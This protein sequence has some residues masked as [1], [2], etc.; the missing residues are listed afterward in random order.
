[1]SF[2]KLAE[3]FAKTLECKGYKW[4]AAA[5]KRLRTFGTLFVL[6]AEGLPFRRRRAFQNYCRKRLFLNIKLKFKCDKVILFRGRLLSWRKAGEIKQIWLERCQRF[7]Q[8]GNRSGIFADNGAVGDGERSWTYFRR[9]TYTSSAW[10][11]LQNV[12]KHVMPSHSHHYCARP[13]EHV[14]LQVLWNPG[15]FGFFMPC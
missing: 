11:W 7:Q 5:P 10:K 14:P 1:M 2:T 12:S 13:H 8:I 6:E 15:L 3:L 4:F 9:V